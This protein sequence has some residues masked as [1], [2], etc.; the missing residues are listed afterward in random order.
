MSAFCGVDVNVDALC[1]CGTIHSRGYV[2]CKGLGEHFLGVNIVNFPDV[3]NLRFCKVQ[4][5]NFGRM[6]C[7]VAS[8]RCGTDAGQIETF[9]T[10]KRAD[11]R[12]EL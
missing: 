5:V 7:G 12:E 6:A 2:P 3:W 9:T 4:R 11:T 10:R 1:A 8:P